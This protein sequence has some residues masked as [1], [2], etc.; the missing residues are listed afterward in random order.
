MSSCRRPKSRS[1]S[2]PNRVARGGV[3]RAQPSV[4]HHLAS[5]PPSTTAR[6]FPEQSVVLMSHLGRPDGTPNKK[7]T[8]APCVDVVK[9]REGA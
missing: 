9:V 3:L 6:A 7:Y 8:L 1:S 2:L 5:R 4:P